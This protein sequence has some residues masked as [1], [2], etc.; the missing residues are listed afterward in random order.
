MDEKMIYGIL[1]S[2]ISILFTLVIRLITKINKDQES[3][4]KKLNTEFYDVKTQTALILEKITSN[5]E[6]VNEVKES[7]IKFREDLTIL[8]LDN[9]D[10]LS[11]KKEV[12]TRLKI[13]ESKLNN[14]GKF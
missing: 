13:I 4:T 12:E 7:I 6:N 1:I 10:L 14:N 11:F 8:Q 9:R 3:T 5:I 2:I